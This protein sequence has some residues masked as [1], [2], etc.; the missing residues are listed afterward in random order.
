MLKR[1]FSKAIANEEAGGT[2]RAS[3]GPFAFGMD[4]GERTSFYSDS[5]LRDFLGTLS[6]N[7]ARTLQGERGVSAHRGRVGEKSGFFSILL[8]QIRLKNNT[9]SGGRVTRSEWGRP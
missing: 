1:P 2:C 6:V 3:C 9:E 4:L 5:D 7:G 8:N